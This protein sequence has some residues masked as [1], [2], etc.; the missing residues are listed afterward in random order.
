MTVYRRSVTG[1]EIQSP[2]WKSGML[3]VR[4][5]LPPCRRYGARVPAE[6]LNLALDV[7][8]EVQYCKL[9]Q[10]MA[11]LMFLCRLTIFIWMI[12][13]RTLSLSCVA[14]LCAHTHKRTV[15]STAPLHRHTDTEGQTINCSPAQCATRSAETAVYCHQ[16]ETPEWYRWLTT[17]N[18]T[19]AS[20]RGHD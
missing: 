20:Q 1:G 2:A 18:R 5:C 12:F 7:N 9:N 11:W 19:T 17:L 15:T 6:A 10:R 16:G 8:H 14:A 4:A 3:H 13:C